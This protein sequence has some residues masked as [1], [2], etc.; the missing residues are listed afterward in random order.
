MR[1]PVGSCKFSFPP[2]D[3]MLKRICTVGIRHRKDLAAV[4]SLHTSLDVIWQLEHH[5]AYRTG[6]LWEFSQ[7]ICAIVLYETKQSARTPLTGHQIANM[8]VGAD[9]SPLM[10]TRTD[11]VHQS[12]IPHTLQPSP[13]YNFS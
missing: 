9:V 2:T 12:D 3:N 7:A 13:E 11:H 10:T 4:L 6:C 5:A 1:I 8:D